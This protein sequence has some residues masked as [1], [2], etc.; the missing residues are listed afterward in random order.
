MRPV[1]DLTIRGK[2]AQRLQDL[3]QREH[4]PVEAVIEALLN[5]YETSAN[6]TEISQGETWHREFRDKL[7]KKARTY[8]RQTGNQERLALTDNQLDDQFWIIDHEGIPRLK[9]DQGAIDLPPDPLEAIDGL[10]ANSDLTDMSTSV[11]ET[12][13]DYYRKKYDRPD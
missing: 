9:S 10:F 5:R 8:W 7:Y 3:A 11:R 1:A 2:T 6:N 13:A 4:R 12:K